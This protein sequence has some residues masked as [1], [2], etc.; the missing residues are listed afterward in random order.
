MSVVKH[1]ENVFICLY[2]VFNMCMICIIKLL[3]DKM[4]EGLLCFP[5]YL[6][7]VGFLEENC[8]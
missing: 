7:K 5:P 2:V 1:S 6:D 3:N 8:H 4:S